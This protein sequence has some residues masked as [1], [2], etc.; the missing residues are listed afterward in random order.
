MKTYKNCQSCGMPLNKDEKGGGT[1]A[2]GTKSEMYCS[3]CY[4]SGK[5][6]NPDM[7]VTQMQDLVKSKLKEMG[8]PGFL[9]GFFT[10][11]IPKLERWK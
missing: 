5:F 6:I 9:A 7:T 11:G 3:K 1:N 2:D 8:F 4:D 10:K